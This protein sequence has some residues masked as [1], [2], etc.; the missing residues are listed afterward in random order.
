MPNLC[1]RYTI[2]YKIKKKKSPR[3]HWEKIEGGEKYKI[4]QVEKMMSFEGAHYLRKAKEESSR[5]KEWFYRQQCLD[6][7]FC[8][9]EQLNHGG[10]RQ[11]MSKCQVAR[12]FSWYS[13]ERAQGTVLIGLQVHFSQLREISKTKQQ[14]W[15]EAALGW[16]MSL[17]KSS[18]LVAQ[19]LTNPTSIHENIGSIPGLA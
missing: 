15:P 14:K 9:N 18:S 10:W 11:V 6:C 19:W 8:S 17:E 16:R 3:I 1:E 13:P 5:Q 4:R 12:G 7:T 2:A